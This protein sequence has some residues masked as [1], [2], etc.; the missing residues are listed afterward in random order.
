MGSLELLKLG[1][2]HTDAS[3]DSEDKVEQFARLIRTGGATAKV[4]NGIQ[5]RRRSRLVLN[6]SWNPI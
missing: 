5:A 4:G 3:N 1:T 6:A 2:F